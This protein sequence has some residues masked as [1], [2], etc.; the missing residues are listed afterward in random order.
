MKWAK[1]AFD[2]IASLA[3]IYIGAKIFILLWPIAS[4][5]AVAGAIACLSV[6]V[7]MIWHNMVV[8]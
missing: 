3:W 8:D 4:P 1:V 7:F 5:L 6:S 2:A